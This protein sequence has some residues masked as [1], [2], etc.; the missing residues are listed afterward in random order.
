MQ[1]RFK[2]HNLDCTVQCGVSNV[3]EI[4]SMSAKTYVCH[5]Q[6]IIIMFCKNVGG[7]QFRM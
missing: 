4:Y 1:Q 2:L 5:V 7:K 3:C 6:P